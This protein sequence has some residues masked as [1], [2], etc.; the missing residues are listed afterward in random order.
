M[1]RCGWVEMAADRCSFARGSRCVGP[2]S[3]VKPR[4]RNRRAGRSRNAGVKR[5]TGNRDRR[6]KRFL[7]GDNGRAEQHQGTNC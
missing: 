7:A 1:M 2:E 6:Q 3:W 4:L 5:E